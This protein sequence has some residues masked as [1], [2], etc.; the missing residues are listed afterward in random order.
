MGGKRMR[1]S[2]GLRWIGFAVLVSTARSPGFGDLEV[3]DVSPCGG[4]GIVEV[5]DLLAMLDAYSEMYACSC[6]GSGGWELTGNA[7]T[8]EATD[9]IGTTDNMSFHVR[10]NNQRV[11]RFEPNATAP[12]VIGGFSANAAAPGVRGAAIGGGGA[13]GNVNLAAGDH[14]AIGGGHSNEARLRSTVGGGHD[15]L[16]SGTNST[17]SGGEHHTASGYAG[18]IGGGAYNVASGGWS[19]VGGGNANTA[20]AHTATVSGGNFNDATA[21]QATV[22]GGSGN[23]AGGTRST[24]GGGQLNT[25]SGNVSTVSGGSSNTASGVASTVCGG[26]NNAAGG[27]YSFAAGRQA[28]V[29]NSAEGGGFFGDEGTFVWADYG[30]AD[31][32]STGANQFLI[33]AS[34]GVGIGT[35]APADPLDVIDALRVTRNGVTSQY[36]QLNSAGAGGHFVTGFSSGSNRKYLGIG[37]YHDGVGTGGSTGIAFYVGNQAAPTEVMRITENGRVGIRDTSPSVELDVI[38]S[39][40]YTGVITDVSDER[41]KENIAPVEKALEKLRRLRGVY[42][43]MKDTPEQR[44][45]GL[46]AQNVQDVLPEAVRVVDPDMGYLG[47]SYASLTA[48]LIEA[49]KESEAQTADWV[50]NNFRDLDALREQTNRELA[51]LRARDAARDRLIAGLEK[52]IERMEARA[53]NHVAP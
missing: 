14:C 4:D 1:T 44:D 21:D 38:G 23:T 24:V 18:S 13:A 51:E 52:R 2:L 20:S 43:N 7:G 16:A 31:F 46:L 37:S 32:I 35:N 50:L 25:A 11:M 30:P 33:R 22:G 41:L 28:K 27:D 45:V 15:N 47:V 5:G 29:R 39:I 26:L 42:F 19:T 10:V 6:P 9:F 8:S 48:L 53:T 34:G 40:N 12:N 49:I 17:V 36:V 3:Y